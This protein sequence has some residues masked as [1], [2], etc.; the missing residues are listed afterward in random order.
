ME[1]R[2]IANDIVAEALIVVTALLES[3]AMALEASE[4]VGQALEFITK[5][6]DYLGQ[7]KSYHEGQ[8]D[9]EV[10]IKEH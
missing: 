9:I 3:D 10:Y 2:L 6:K 7:N 5:A 4:E 8:L 1:N